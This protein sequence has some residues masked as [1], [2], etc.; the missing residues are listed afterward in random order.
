MEKSEEILREL[1]KG[2]INPNE[3]ISVSEE[4]KQLVRESN[5]IAK[6]LERVIGNNELIDKYIEIKSQITSIECES[7][8]I[9]GYK[10]ASQLL[11][12]GISN[13]I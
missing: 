13:N 10:I 7:K 4:Y 3:N 11:I 1:Y 2:K 5:E 6:E 12:S 8:F 9:E